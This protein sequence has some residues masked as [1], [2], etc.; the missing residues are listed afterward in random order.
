M[1][2]VADSQGCS[3]VDATNL[4]ALSASAPSGSDVS[5]VFRGAGTVD[6]SGEHVWVNIAWLR[7]AA[8]SVVPEAERSGWIEGFEAM[9]GYA[10]S[11]GWV[12][13]DGESVRAHIE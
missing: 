8:C 4:R 2:V 9:I 1:I 6:V 11:K 7:E 3:V 12:S 5:D 13:A 10:T